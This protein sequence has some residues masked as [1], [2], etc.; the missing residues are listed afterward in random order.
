VRRARLLCD[1][2]TRSLSV[3]LLGIDQGFQ[4][5][6]ALGVVGKRLTSSVE[7]LGSVSEFFSHGLD[8]MAR[9]PLSS[10][11]L[12]D[13][14]A[15]ILG[16]RFHQDREVLQVEVMLL[17]NILAGASLFRTL[18][19]NIVVPSHDIL[20]EAVLDSG[21]RYAGDEQ[22]IEGLVSDHR[23][24]HAVGH[25]GVAFDALLGGGQAGKG[26]NVGHGFDCMGWE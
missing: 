26:L 9:E 24:P 6:V 13:G 21:S 23:Q 2:P 12:N 5:L 22:P 20:D 18:K 16:R 19:D 15:V 8:C 1:S 17:L 10:A 25:G 11:N 7:L 4:R 14:H 3:S